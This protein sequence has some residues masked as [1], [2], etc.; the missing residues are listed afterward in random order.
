MSRTQYYIAITLAILSLI[1]SVVLVFFSKSTEPLQLQVRDRQLEVNRGTMIQEM[2]TDI[3]KDIAAASVNDEDLKALLARNGYAVT[4]KPA[5]AKP[6]APSAGGA[7]PGS[8]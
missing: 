8:P 6:P 4:F 3:L 1:F 5:N 7:T 2:G